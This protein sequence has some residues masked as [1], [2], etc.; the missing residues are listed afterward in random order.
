MTRERKS[1][2]AG[3]L[4]QGDFTPGREPR[5]LKILIKLSAVLLGGTLLAALVVY[6]INV[7]YEQGINEVGKKTRTLTEMNKELLVRL[8][9]IQSYKNVEVAAEKV[10]QLHLSEEVVDVVGVQ[11]VHLPDMPERQGAF[12]HVEGY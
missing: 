11:A 7:H 3:L 6:G 8:N 10:P 2:H 9:Q 4:I 12:P 1:E 5:T